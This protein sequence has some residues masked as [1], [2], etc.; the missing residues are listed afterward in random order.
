MLKFLKITFS[1]LIILVTTSVFAQEN[2]FL[3]REFWK[4]DPSVEQVEKA[5]ADG[6]DIT[7]LN[8]NMFDG[9]CY[10]LLENV[11]NTTVKHLL[12]KKGNEV[13]KITHDGRTYI[14]WAAYRNNMEIVKYLVAN[15]AKANIED[16]HGYSVINFAA[17]AGQ[18][19]T[20]I[21]DF[22][23]ENEADIAATTRSGTNALLLLA[24]YAND[25]DLVQYFLDKGL[26]LDSTDDNGSGL[27]HY[28]AKGGDIE[29]LKTLIGKGV[30]YKGINNQGENAILWASRGTRG[31]QNGLATY[32]YLEGLG[33]EANIVN[34]NGRN[35]LHAISFDTEDLAIY[36][37][38][39]GKGVDVNQQDDGGDSP[40]M[41][42]AN[43]N[44]EEV[45]AFLADFVTDI[46]TKDGNGRSALAM[47]VNRNSPEVVAYLLSKKA[48]INT[49]DKKG[50]TLAYYLGT[51]FNAKNPER[52]EAKLK[53]LQEAGLDLTK[54]QNNG[55]TLLHLAA[56]DNDLA[57]LKRLEVFEMD[58]NQK[59]K[60]GNTPLH[61]A[62]MTSNNSVILK[63]L[64]AQ[65]ADK[66]AKT[67]FEETVY[68]LAMENELLQQ[69][70]IAL[71]FLK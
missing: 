45:V 69:Q 26:S 42:A 53:L 58:I 55:N 8:S 3:D 10:A 33:L 27:F 61:L 7:Q 40:F 52:F 50:N 48:D 16:S 9:V 59:N 37:Y 71:D 57:F 49:E 39:I 24:P 5:I 38:F 67:E 35:P 32:K 11:N 43:S 63:Y 46:N 17:N 34:K 12:Q 28:A 15:G 2:V 54:P 60:E 23:I 44:T 31:K 18:T 14:F 19:N 51:N 22:L 29:F 25:F 65:G 6:N 36:N 13:D 20:K 41:N 30:P 62:A 1:V 66:A 47:A 64:I 56:K 70:K 4:A 68:D 21:Y